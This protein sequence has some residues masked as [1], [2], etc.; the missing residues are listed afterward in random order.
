MKHLNAKI[1]A[2][3]KKITELT[4]ANNGLRTQIGDLNKKVFVFDPK[5]S[6]CPNLGIECK[7]YRE[8]NYKVL[9]AKFN[10]ELN[11]EAKR[12]QEQGMANKAEI[13]KLEKENNALAE[14]NSL[15]AMLRSEKSKTLADL[16]KAKLGVKTSQSI[17][18]ENPRYHEL[19]K[20]DKECDTQIE[21][22]VKAKPD[23][24]Q[25]LTDI[26]NKQAEIEKIQLSIGLYDAHKLRENRIAEL[27]EQQRKLSGGLS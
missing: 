7:P 26:K 20:E 15:G 22:L 17:M 16:E 5:T 14:G 10:T 1:E 3:T 23:N 27:K 18:E 13:E 8:G 2:N 9:E 21:E 24:T 25:I 12:I 4:E 6:L 19:K 11:T